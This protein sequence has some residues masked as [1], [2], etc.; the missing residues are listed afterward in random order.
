[1]SH[2]PPRIA[3]E[4]L[5]AADRQAAP[6]NIR[7]G[8]LALSVAMSVLF[9]LHRY[10][11]SSIGPTIKGE[12]NADDAEFGRAASAFFYAYALCQIPAG[13]LADRI[14]GRVVLS[15][16]VVAWSL[17]LMLVGWAPNIWLV[18]V[19]LAVLG[20][21]QAAAYPTAAGYL[22]HW[23]PLS[24][25][26]FANGLVTMGGRAGHMLATFGTPLLVFC[27]LSLTGWSVG[28]WRVVFFLYGLLGLVWTA[29][30]W[31]YFRDR[32]GEHPHC[33]AGEVALIA[34]GQPTQ[35]EA[36]PP[37]PWG[38]LLS[39]GN[40]WLICGINFFQNIAWIFLA[41]WPVTYLNKVY[42]VPEV[43]AGTFGALI[44]LFG[45]LGNLGGGFATDRFVQELGQPWGRR[46]TGL[47]G[48]GVA[49]GLYSVC[50]FG[51]GLYTMIALFAAIWFFLD[52]ELG[53]RWGICQD[54][55]GR[56]VAT[57]VGFANMCGNLGAGIFLQTIGE[58]G[59]AGK[60]EYLFAISCGALLCT[61]LCWLFI[62]PRT[63]VVPED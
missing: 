21:C 19:G 35:T 56:Y 44:A 27:V 62:D 36:A 37:I 51:E 30:F 57:I 63:P 20:V 13:L 18:G 47:L 38:K 49:C 32:P 48:P 55:G 34:G 14:G 39:S 8:V 2:D 54:F 40:L 58:L 22:K 53:A 28:G 15:I 61:V 42:G 7:Y 43:Q 29:L 59:K 50:F 60:W 5:L 31:G 6:T 16:C 17:V 3:S 9:Y 11:T 4:P 41:A 26:G 46:M 45:V 10:A 24:S 12:L 25:R 23:M 52:F 1:M 33:N